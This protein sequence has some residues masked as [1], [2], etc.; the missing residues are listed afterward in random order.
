MLTVSKISLDDAVRHKHYLC[1]IACRFKIRAHTET[2]L[3]VRNQSAAV[4]KIEKNRN[5]VEHRCSMTARGLKQIISGKPFHVFMANF[6]TKPVHF[7]KIY[8]NQLHV[9]WTHLNRTCMRRWTVRA[10][11]ILQMTIQSKKVED[12]HSMKAVRDKASECCERQVDDTM[13]WLIQ[14]RIQNTMRKKNWRWQTNI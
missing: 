7:P 5:I 14:K 13:L 4:M 3:M 2:I 10:R 11:T 1:C 6:R 12:E 9:K 8:G